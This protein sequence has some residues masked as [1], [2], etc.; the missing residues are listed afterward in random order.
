MENRLV[1]VDHLF[2]YAICE[3]KIKCRETPTET[4]ESLVELTGY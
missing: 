3:V 4:I 2:S 1:V